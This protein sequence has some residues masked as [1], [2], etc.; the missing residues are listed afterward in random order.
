MMLPLVLLAIGAAAAGFIPFGKYVSSDGKPLCHRHFTCNFPLH[1]YCWDLQ[2]F[3]R[4]CAC[5][6]K[7][8]NRPKAASHGLG[9]IY[10]A[11]YNKFY[12]DEIYLFITK[13]ILFNLVARPAPGST[14]ILVDGLVTWNRKNYRMGIRKY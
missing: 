10:T 6:K 1:L 11:A 13:K 5:I 3:Y 7:E 14:G 2:E 8:N 9:V 12:I 4:P